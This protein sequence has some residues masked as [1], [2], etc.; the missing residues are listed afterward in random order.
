MPQISY[1]MGAPLNAGG[2]PHN[3]IT[4]LASFDF[5]A[6]VESILAE[7]EAL[8]FTGEFAVGEWVS[9]SLGD[10]KHEDGKD[11]FRYHKLVQYRIIDLD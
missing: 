2:Y 8:G 10:V 3:Q 9:D 7:A 6:D 5:D 1:V 4:R 11:L